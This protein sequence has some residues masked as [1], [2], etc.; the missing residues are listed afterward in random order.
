MQFFNISQNLFNIFFTDS[1]E[2]FYKEFSKWLGSIDAGEFTLWSVT[3]SVCQPVSCLPSKTTGSFD[4]YELG[5]PGGT[6]AVNH[7][8][9]YF[10]E[11][12]YI[13][14][15]FFFG[16]KDYPICAVTFHDHNC[17]NAADQIEKYSEYISKRVRELSASDK[18]MDLYVDYQKKVDFVKKAGVIFKALEVE[19]VISVS[20]AFFAEVFSADAVCA[21]QKDKFYGIGLEES[22]LTQNIFID[23][24]PMHQ[25][26][27]QISATEFTEHMGYSLKFNI[28][29]I[30][31][32]YEETCGLRFALFNVMPDV[33]PDREFSALVSQIVSIA[34][35]NALN[36]EEMT[37]FKVEETEMSHTVDIL[38]RF[39]V[40][41]VNPSVDTCDIFAMN[42]PAK[43]A[44]G[45]FV[46]IK[47]E[48]GKIKFC[49]ADVCGK[50]YSA[51]ILTVVLSVFFSGKNLTDIKDIIQDLN[52]FLLNKNFGD[53]FITGFFGELD[54]EKRTLKYIYCGHEPAVLI[55]GNNITTLKS[56]NLPLGIMPE[57][58]TVKTTVI[59]KGAT[60]FAYTDGLLEYSDLDGIITL[61]QQ[62]K[63][64]T[65]QTAAE[66]LYA[67]LV[68]D[69]ETQ[70]DDFTCILMK[71]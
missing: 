65:S 47:T 37:R 66:N 14:R 22:D 19:S 12:F 54:T 67:A 25:Y 36:H 5:Y 39:V 70:K 21:L 49:I 31:F 52:S 33:V 62:S 69:P 60:F 7:Q 26:L 61:L 55:D 58:Y 3:G 41:K 6:N 71:L 50:G 20:L 48:D 32:V 30:F 4:I 23:N 8:V 59:P 63:D 35:E 16:R 57:D 40:N 38:N 13:S 51:A 68:T 44:G 2:N 46:D 24:M 27:S 42:C 28:Q 43:K 29:N 1:F 15:A 9:S 17:Q 18:S 10:D 53:K 34:V 64:S 45:D 11:S 56:E